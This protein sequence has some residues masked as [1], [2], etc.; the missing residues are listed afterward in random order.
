MYAYGLYQYDLV[1]Q[2]HEAIMTLL[3]RAQHP[4]AHL[5]VGIPE[6]FNDQG[7]GKYSYLTGS[8]SWLLK[9]MRTEVFGIHFHLGA[10]YFK[11]KLKS[12][13]FIDGKASI[14]TYVKG[15]LTHVVYLNPKS[16]DH[17]QYVIKK[18]LMQGKA[19]T[20]PIERIEGDI[21]VYLDETV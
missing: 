13:D 10:L 17:G 5:W 12:S 9:V 18:I 20:Q 3:H 11:P 16:L 7:V 8:A 15:R 14:Q 4:D 6:Y 19:I 2:G 1:D 21:E